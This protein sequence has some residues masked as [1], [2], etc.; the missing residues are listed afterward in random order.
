MTEKKLIGYKV[1]KD[2][3]FMHQRSGEIITVPCD[4]Q[5]AQFSEYFEP[6]FEEPNPDELGI[7]YIACS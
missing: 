6:V 5:F 7:F 4:P 3:P 2:Y 1:I